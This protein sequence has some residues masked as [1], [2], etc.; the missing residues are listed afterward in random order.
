MR[1]SGD[2]LP[3]GTYRAVA[4]DFVE[5]GQWEDRKFLEE[6]RADAVRFTLSE[7]GTETLSLKL[8]ASVQR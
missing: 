7:G 4:R 6:A 3:A 8:P 2:D 1:P 5:E